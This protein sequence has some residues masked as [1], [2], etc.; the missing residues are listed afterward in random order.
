MRC[1]GEGNE[2]VGFAKLC[3]VECGGVKWVDEGIGVFDLF[4]FCLWF[5]VGIGLKH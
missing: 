2:R 1:D 3:F 4:I 5:L